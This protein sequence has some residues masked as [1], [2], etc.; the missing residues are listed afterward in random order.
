MSSLVVNRASAL[1]LNAVLWFGVLGLAYYFVPDLAR[2]RVTPSEQRPVFTVQANELNRLV[3]RTEV[4]TSRAGYANV[5]HY[6][7]PYDRDTDFTVAFIVW[8]SPTRSNKDI[9][10]EVRDF[11][12]MRGM[13]FSSTG[14]YHDLE[15][16]FG[17]VHAMEFTTIADGRQKPCLGFVSR[18]DPGFVFV[19]GWFCQ[20]N[21]ARPSPAMLACYLD[22]IQLGGRLPSP[23]AEAFIQ[24]G[25]KR[26]PRCSASPVTQTIDTSPA[27]RPTYI[28]TG[29]LL[30]RL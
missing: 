24:D 7:Q 5:L 15:T 26:P 23:D 9:M 4:L 8:S 22:A 10:S 6:G 20:A 2:S 30:R 11:Q 19:K 3:K 12:S 28:G 14:G 18:F 25:M 16:R 29:S 13:G 21:G 17:P 27:R 1:A